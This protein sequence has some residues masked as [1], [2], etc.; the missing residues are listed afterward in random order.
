LSR[1][2][3]LLALVVAVAL[4]VDYGLALQLLERRA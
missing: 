4:F 2:V 1:S 3:C